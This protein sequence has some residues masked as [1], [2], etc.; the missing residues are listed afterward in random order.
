MKKSMQERYYLKSLCSGIFTVLLMLFSPATSWERPTASP[1]NSVALIQDAKAIPITHVGPQVPTQLLS[2]GQVRPVSL[3]RGDFDH[4]GVEDLVAGYAARDGSGILVLHRGNIDAFA[5]PDHES[6]LAI[7]QDRFPSPFL[8]AATALQVPRAPDF[9]ASGNF[10]GNNHLDL[11]TATR[12]DKTLYLLAGDG[13]GNFATPQAIALPGPVAAMAAGRFGVGNL[14]S[15]VIVGAGG[16][17]PAILLYSRSNQ[18]LSLV[19]RYPLSAPPT[20]FAFDDLD[21]DGL[22]DVAMVAGGQVSILHASGSGG[23][24]EIETLSLPISSVSVTTGFFVHDRGWRRQIAILDQS[25]AVSIVAHGGFDPRGWTKAEAKAMHDALFHRRQNPFARPQSGPAT[26]GWKIIETLP[27]MAFDVSSVSAPLLLPS[28]ISGRATDDLLVIDSEA[29]K[30][31]VATHPRVSSKAMSITPADLSTQTYSGGVPVAALPFPVNVD[32]REGLVLL[33]QSQIA[34]A[35][36]MPVPG[37]HTLARASVG[38]IDASASG[39]TSPLLAASTG[40]GVQ[41][42]RTGTFFVNRTDDPA[43]PLDSSGNPDLAQFC[44]NDSPT[45]TSSPCSLREA[46]VEVNGDATDTSLSP[47]KIMIAAG[48]YHLSIPGAFTLDATTGHLDI[49]SP[50]TI[51]GE[52]MSGPGATIIQADPSLLDQVFLIAPLEEGVGGFPLAIRNLAIQGAQNIDK[53][54]ITAG[55]AIFWDAGSDGSGQLQLSHVNVNNNGN[56]DP[57]TAGFND[58]GGIALANGASV[59]TPAL[60]RIR[61]SIIANNTAQD[62]GGGIFVAGAVS[63]DMSNTKVTGNQAAGGGAQQGGGIFLCLCGN[64]LGNGNSSPSLIQESAISGNIAG[65]SNTGEGAG[66]FTQQSLTINEGSMLK[67]NHVGAFGGGITTDLS[68]TNDQVVITGTTITENQA[69]DAAGVEVTFNSIANLQL[70][71][72]RI[73]KN[74]ISSAISS[75]TSGLINSGTGAVNAIDNWWGCNEGPQTPP[76]GNVPIAIFNTGANSTGGLDPDGSTDVHYNLVGGSDPSVGSTAFVANAVHSPIFPNG[77]WLLNDI[78]S[79]WLSPV[80]N[81]N[82]GLNAGTYVYQTTFDLTGVDPSTVT[83]T[84]Q[85]AAAS[86]GSIVLN[87]VPV[88]GASSPGPTGLSG[89]TINSGFLHG[90]NT[91]D[92]V[93]TN[94]FL[95]T[96]LGTSPNPT[97]LRVQ[98]SGSG[99]ASSSC[100]LVSEIFG[101]VNV[102]PWIVLKNIPA[103]T[104]LAIGALTRL[105]ASFLQD[106][107]GAP[108]SA[109]NLGA[110]IGLSIRFENPVNGRLSHAQTSIKDTATATARLK[111]KADPLA[112]VDAVVDNATAAAIVPV[113]DFNL[114]AGPV[115]QNANVGVAKTFTYEISISQLNGFNGAVSLSCSG[116]SDIT[117]TCSPTSLTGEGVSALKVSTTD[118]TALGP[119]SIKIAASS[120]RI[121]RT[122]EVVLNVADFSISLSPSSQTVKT[123]QQAIYTITCSTN[124]GF[125]GQVQLSTNVPGVFTGNFLDCPGIA[126]LTVNEPNP[127]TFTEVVSATS[128]TATRNAEATLIIQP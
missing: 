58:G 3:A 50:V 40:T 41:T 60:V 17:Q 127:G 8:V 27:G 56:S 69:G 125:N 128:G 23:K 45:D 114:T 49:K 121:R 122:T 37:L 20:S 25:G 59:T 91:L 21:G 26:D 105:T 34:P 1:T 116:P 103:S 30:M 38:K 36:M 93:V 113:Q 75:G 100:D 119:H 4:D 52:G 109:S 46:V 110:L 112:R 14:P 83:L 5:P 31:A 64:P 78:N 47:D 97:G 29:G 101:P 61:H 79:K 117:V 88:A 87:G 15:T 42:Q 92:F 18:G 10:V 35:V 89:F 63:M 80:A 123:G 57:A 71:F 104:P 54:L 68:G 33:N 53:A 16:I 48:T 62:F 111:V 76:A 73:F 90:I 95:T 13:E 106:S 82:T 107:S 72:N 108:L 28:R 6:W 120:G 77:P 126:G 19:A 24:P 84:G 32:A 12:G 86:F 124:T 22:P 9:L 118:S 43:I 44:Q 85:W 11:V 70:N 96:F 115:S 98:I 74:T 51:V 65:G 7:G 2:A 67:G 39:L 81:A 94:N 102:S 66:I 99:T 55:S